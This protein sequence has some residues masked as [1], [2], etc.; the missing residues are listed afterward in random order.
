MVRSTPRV[1]HFSAFIFFGLLKS[2]TAWSIVKRGMSET[3]KKWVG[4]SMGKGFQNTCLD[5]VKFRSTGGLMNLAARPRQDQAPL[6][7]TLDGGT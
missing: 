1:L 2:N 4:E 6:N 3:R 7:D 5:K